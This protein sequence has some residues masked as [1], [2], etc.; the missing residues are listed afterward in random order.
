MVREVTP[1]RRCREEGVRA[2]AVQTRHQTSIRIAPSL[3]SADFARLGEEVRRAEEGGADLLHLDIM[4]GHFVPNLTFGPPVVAAVR[5][6]TG[7]VLEAHLMIANPERYIDEYARAGA[8]WISVHVETC[9][10]LHRVLAMIRERGPRAGVAL[11]PATPLCFLEPILAD[12]DFVLLMSVNPGFGGQSFI[13]AVLDKIS[14]AARL[15]AAAGRPVDL[16][17]DG[18]VNLD[19]VGAVARAGANVLVAGSAVYGVP[20][21]GAPDITAA[22][23]GL[24]QAAEGARGAGG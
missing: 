23:R 15:I 9:T 4:D 3:L 6:N 17:V 13:P 10:H 1:G 18:G 11:N 19:T 24:R 5:R 22:I 7:L 12:V 14:A 16:E 21:H 20:A 8:D 2:V